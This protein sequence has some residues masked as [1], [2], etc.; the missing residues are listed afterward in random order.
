MQTTT[1]IRPDTVHC[2]AIPHGRQFAL[3]SLAVLGVVYGDIVERYLPR[4]IPSAMSAFTAST[5]SPACHYNIL[6]VLSLIFWAARPC[7]LV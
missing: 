5:Q 3:L 1:V 2:P 6:G 4:C 7:H